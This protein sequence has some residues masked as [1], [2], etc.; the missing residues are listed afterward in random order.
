MDKY[1]VAFVGD[2]RIHAAF[3]TIDEKWDM[4]IPLE[5]LDAFEAELNKSEEETGISKKT[6]L[7]VM[8]SRLYESNPDKFATLAAYTAPFSVLCILIPEA[9]KGAIPTIRMAIN[10]KQRLFAKEYEGSFNDNV[11]IFFVTYENVQSEIYDSIYNFSQSKYIDEETRNI[12]A[13]MLPD[14]QIPKI[15]DYPEFEDEDDPDEIIIPEKGEG[16]SGKII[17]VT[18]SKGGSGKSTITMLLSKYILDSS[19]K[20]ASDGLI[21]QPLKVVVVDLD[22]R[23]GQLGFLN[24]TTS[25]NVID[26]IKNGVPSVENVKQGIYHNPNTGVDF[27]FAPKRPKNSDKI[28]DSYYA[29]VIATLRMMYDIV[30]IDTSVN[31]LDSLLS[32]VAYPMADEIVFVSDFG[33]SSI[34]GMSRWIIE[35]TEMDSGNG[36]PV[37]SRNKIQI[38]LNKS[39]PNVNMSIDKIEKAAKGVPITA[40]FPSQPA[41]V[42]YMSNTC[43]TDQI[44]NNEVFRNATAELVES[45]LE[46]RVNELPRINGTI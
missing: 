15:D 14:A 17:T 18:S 36:S 29:Q 6:S 42:T 33:I 13:T 20:A 38:A 24:G 30:V 32:K 43:A 21:T 3:K 9:E 35:N 19:R 40:V 45:V 5:T 4:Q 41:L 10:E 11:P 31:Y 39:I 16:K 23:D 22:T 7:I 8:F 25:P 37:T 46:E 34:F 2:R 28:K 12:I 26:I 44:L 1:P 27:L